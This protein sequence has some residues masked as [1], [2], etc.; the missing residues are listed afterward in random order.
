MKLNAKALRYLDNEDMRVLTATEMG[1]KNHQVV[2]ISIIS[3]L[4]NIKNS[5]L[6]KIIGE[7]ARLKLVAKMQNIKYEGYRLTYVLYI[8]DPF[9]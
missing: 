6:N 4:S 3:Q 2:P 9:C 1:M 5:G 8:V 7:L